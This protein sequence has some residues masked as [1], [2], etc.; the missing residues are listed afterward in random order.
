[1]DSKE[2]IRWVYDKTM[3]DSSLFYSDSSIRCGCAD[4]KHVVAWLLGNGELSE[5][6]QERLERKGIVFDEPTN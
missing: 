2:E 1:M 5:E 3:V 6:Y 4:C